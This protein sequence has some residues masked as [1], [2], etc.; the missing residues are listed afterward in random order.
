MSS[1]KEDVTR[2]QSLISDAFT[3]TGGLA[4]LANGGV[5]NQEKLQREL[6]QTTEKFEQAALE[7]RVLAEKNS[8]GVGSY[9]RR[10][11]LPPIEITGSVNIIEYSW[12]HIRLNTLLPHCRF[13]TP[14][15]LSDTIRRLLDD[16]ERS[17]GTLPYFKSGA[18]LCIDEYSSIESRTVY[19]QD[20]KGW[21]AVSNTL[22]GRIF[23][24]DD[25]YTLGVM[26]L[27]RKSAENATHITVMDASSAGDFLSLRNG[28]AFITDVYSG[29]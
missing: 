12:L 2:I 21:K 16:F 4:A 6:E 28:F 11:H 8:P 23:P 3:E 20:N 15:W 27:S 5:M 26:L 14:N 1:F 24:D 25:Q 19:D 13:Q 9:G 10:P 18:I 29:I 7:L 17:G 22:K